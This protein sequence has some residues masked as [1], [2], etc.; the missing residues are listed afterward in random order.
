MVCY[1]MS[2]IVS[3]PCNLA[4]HYLRAWIVVLFNLRDRNLMP[5][6]RTSSRVYHVSAKVPVTVFLRYW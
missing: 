1:L 5:M 3:L 2:L 6:T 4:S